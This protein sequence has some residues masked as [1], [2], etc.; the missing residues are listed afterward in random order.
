MLA[1]CKNQRSEANRLLLMPLQHHDPKTKK[2][3]NKG[4]KSMLL[5]RQDVKDKLVF[6]ESLYNAQALSKQVR[7]E[8]LETGWS[9]GSPP[10]KTIQ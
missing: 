8:V 4:R 1:G 3:K 5:D 2:K 9:L 7:S 10:T 6:R